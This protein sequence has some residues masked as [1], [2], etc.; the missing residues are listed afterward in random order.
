MDPCHPGGEGNGTAAREGCG[1][2]G[3]CFILSKNETVDYSLISIK[4]IS[5]PCKPN[6]ISSV[7][8]NKEMSLL[9]FNF[10]Q[11]RKCILPMDFGKLHPKI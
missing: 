10:Y 5:G 4:T 3:Q 11:K 8:L 6:W 7:K 2:K 1:V 9:L